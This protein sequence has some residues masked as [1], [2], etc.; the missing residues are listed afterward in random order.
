MNNNPLLKIFI[1]L[2]SLIGILIC[3]A[4]GLSVFAVNSWVKDQNLLAGSPVE[5]EIV[6]PTESVQGSSF[7]QEN[8]PSPDSP[9]LESLMMTEIPI[10]DPIDIAERLNGQENLPLT[11]PV[12]NLN[13]QI[14]DQEDFW[15]INT[16]TAENYQITAN[17]AAV[18]DHLYFWIEDGVD[19]SQKSINNLA[20]DFENNIYPIDQEFFGTEWFPGVDE[21]PHIYVIMASGLG[22]NVAGLFNS[23][24]EYTPEVNEYSNAHETFLLNAD[25]IRLDDPYTYGVMAHEFQHMI[26][27]YRDKNETSWLNE[28]FSE[29]ATLLTGYRNQATHDYFFADNP[30]TQL[31]DWPNDPNATTPHYG[32]AFLFVTYFMDRFGSEA[33]KALVADELNGLPSVDEVLR[34]L[35]IKDPATGA[36]IGADDVFLDWA[37]TNYLK[38]EYNVSDRFKY[39]S[40]PDSP[41]FDATEVIR[42]CPTGP[43]ARDVHQ[44]A[45]DYIEINCAQD[46]TLRFTGQRTVKLIPEDPYEGSYA[47]WSNKGDHSDMRLTREFDL[48]DVAGPVSLQYWT[49]YDLEE[50]YDYLFLEIST[51]GKDWRIIRTPSS[52]SEN[53][54]G[55]SYGWGYNGLSGGNGTWIQETVDLSSYAGEVIQIR[56]E[57]ITDAAVHGEGF[58]LDAVSVPALDYYSGFETDN[59][60]WTPEGF[61]RIANSLPQTYRLALIHLGPTPQVEYLALTDGNQLDLPLTAGDHP[62]V[63]VVSGTTRYTR[64]IANYW[65]EIDPQ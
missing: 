54:S 51:N 17:L 55:N 35:K 34:E 24:D 23:T 62:V 47:F 18:T 46:A 43:L 4:C 56:F 5:V 10:N 30:D 59:G 57:Y 36:Q 9:T 53:P 32:N 8:L 42:D 40:Y 19:Y 31:N 44:Y 58:L 37:V 25:N 28:G 39:L 33:T 22:G 20:D 14:G 65:I 1:G 49:W 64:Q 12:E 6:H 2:A 50:D 48:R 15:V 7:S 11:R 27:W 52:T 45:V 38:D 63:L 3:L 61:V 26:H 60:G 29:L 16:D 13:R 41:Y 21:D